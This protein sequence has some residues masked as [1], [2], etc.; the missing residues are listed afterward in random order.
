MGVKKLYMSFSMI[1]IISAG[2]TTKSTSGKCLMLPVTKKE[3]S[4]DKATS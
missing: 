3:S 2:V 4:F 1:D